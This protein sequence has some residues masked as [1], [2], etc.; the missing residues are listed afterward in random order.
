M[1]CKI[2][3]KHNFSAGLAIGGK[4]LQEEAQRISR[5]NIMICTPGRILQHMDQTSGF[6]VSNLQILV[7]DE[8]D[9]ILDMGF[10]KTIDAII[11]NIPKNR[12]TLL[13]SATQTKRVKDLSRLS[14]RNPDYIAVHEKEASSTPPTLE[15]YYSIVLLHEKIN[16]LFSFLRTN[17]KAKVLVFM[18]TSKQVWV[19]FC[20]T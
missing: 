17:L 15:Q 4:D 1:L 6:D 7:L 5:M 14:L 12:Q 3:K 10:Q 2:G 11:E 20:D 19:N 18:S 16:A 13:F 9:C 8:A